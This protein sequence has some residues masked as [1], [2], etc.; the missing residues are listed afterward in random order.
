METWKQTR[1]LRRLI[2]LR[3]LEADGTMAALIL[4]TGSIRKVKALVRDLS[5]PA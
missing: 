4:T 2:T 5:N 1:V 3:V